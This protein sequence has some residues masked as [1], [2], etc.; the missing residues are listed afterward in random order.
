MLCEVTH[1]T[2]YVSANTMG[3]KL[4]WGDWEMG[5]AILCTKCSQIAKR[6]VEAL[7]R[8]SSLCAA[9]FCSTIIVW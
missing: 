4:C 1:C 6:F 8:H 9:V 3:Y 7:Q 2:G 5:T